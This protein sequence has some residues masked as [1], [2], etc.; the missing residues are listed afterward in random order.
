MAVESTRS[1]VLLPLPFGPMSPKISPGR[2]VKA[3][4]LDAAS[5]A[6]VAERYVSRF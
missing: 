4:A 5:A 3:H 1:R 6:L 2:T